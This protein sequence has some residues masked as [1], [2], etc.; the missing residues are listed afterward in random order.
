MLIFIDKLSVLLINL[1]SNIAITFMI[2][3]GLYLKKI[4]IQCIL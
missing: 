1:N 3:S 4:N 2:L